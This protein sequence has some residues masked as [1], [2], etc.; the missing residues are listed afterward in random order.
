MKKNISAFCLLLCMLAGVGFSVHAQTINY[1]INGGNPG[2]P[3][4]RITGTL[5]TIPSGGVINANDDI[6]MPWE[7]PTSGGNTGYNFVVTGLP[8][9]ATSVQWTLRG[10]IA[11][12]AAGGSSAAGTSVNVVHY[13]R[14]PRVGSSTDLAQSKGRVTLSYTIANPGCPPAGFSISF[15]VHKQFAGTN[16]DGVQAGP[17]AIAIPAVVGP[18]CLLPN[19][20]YTYSVDPIMSDNL[21]AQIGIDR[22]FW[23]EAT[24]V[25]QGFNIDYYSTDSSSIT[26]TT[27]ATVPSTMSITCGLGMSN[28]PPLQ[29][30]VAQQAYAVK[31]LQAATGTPIVNL[32]GAATGPITAGT[33]FCVNTNGA[34]A[35]ALTFTVV[36]QPGAT[37]TW[38]FGTVGA[39]G[40]G[41]VNGWNTF[42]AQPGVPPYNTTGT[43][44]T[45]NNIFNQ[46]GVVSLK[47]TDACG[48]ETYYHYEIKRALLPAHANL[49]TIANTC[50]TPGTSSAVTLAS[51]ASLNTLNWTP[52]VNWTM[53]Q[54]DIMPN[55]S[56]APGVYTLS[57]GFQS[58]ASTASYTVRVRPVSIGISPVCFAR[59]TAANPVNA[60]PAA[61]SGYTW[62]V[63]PGTAGTI[64]GTTSTASLNTNSISPFTITS[65]YTVAA[66]CSTTTAVTAGL[67]PIAPV[68]VPPS[69]I[70]S[71]PGGTAAL[72]I[73]NY[74]GYGTYTLTFVSGT[75]IF[76]TSSSSGGTITGTLNGATGSGTY[77]VT[78][79]SSPCGTAVSSITLS[80][81]TPPFTVSSANLGSFVILAANPNTNNYTWY[82]CT[83]GTVI[84]STTAP[85]ASIQLNTSSPGANNN[86]GAQATVGGCT[87][88]VCIPVPNWLPRLNG[89]SGGVSTLSPDVA[90]VY[91]NPNAGTFNI[92]LKSDDANASATVYDMAGKIMYRTTLN[93]GV[94]KVNDLQVATGQYMVVLQVNGKLYTKQIS[95]SGK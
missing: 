48:T 75:N 85:N 14:A 30:A 59:N 62:S 83:N 88:R 70:G 63:S 3:L 87:Y 13:N 22:Y 11:T 58:C 95:V 31:T 17:D 79:N 74:P 10:D 20:Q 86:Y 94:N 18:N 55:G 19:Q 39:F 46:P 66:G 56:V 35:T 41:S 47:V 40:T 12:S 38:T 82:N 27:G 51:S 33:P 77:N 32:S 42:P 91:P 2:G 36:P 25:A 68:V 81:T 6:A 60:I 52:L 71:V 80:T 69:C 7:L 84:G 54:T 65:T 8:A 9:G 16:I 49:L 73:S 4:S 5:T 89:N 24:L 57:T 43:S 76:S 29:P 93:P 53:T 90:A 45:I 1:T 26:F 72:T 92:D 37:Y 67:N 23:D 28:Y 78:H 64:S 61:A 34:T 44:L 15:D 50:L 21:F